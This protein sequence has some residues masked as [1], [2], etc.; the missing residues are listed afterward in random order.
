[1]VGFSGGSA[2]TRF[3]QL[4]PPQRRERYAEIMESLFSGYAKNAGQVAVQAWPEDPWTQG[5]YCSPLLGQVTTTFP[6]L[7]EGVANRLFFAG[8]HASPSFYGYMEGALQSGVR[9]AK[10]VAKVLNLAA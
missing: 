3:L 2:A 8:E 1:L 6:K 4:A 7:E 9:A 10:Q 5:G